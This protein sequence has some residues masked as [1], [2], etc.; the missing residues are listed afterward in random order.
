M[1]NNQRTIGSSFTLEGPTL[2]F[3]YRVR[4]EMLPA[5]CDHGIIA[6]VNDHQV[7]L[8]E[9]YIDYEQLQRRTVVKNKEYSINTIEHFLAALFGLGI[10]NLII[11]LCSPD[12]IPSHLW[13]FPL[14]DGCSREYSD[15]LLKAGIVEQD[16]GRCYYSYP[17]S[18]HY[19]ANSSDFAYIPWE[20]DGLVITTTIY[21]P[22]FL[23]DVQTLSLFITEENFYQELSSARTF[24]FLEDVEVLKKKGLIKGGTL[25]EALVLGKDSYLNPD[26]RFKDEPVRHKMLDFLGDLKL[27]GKP[28]RG[29]LLVVLGGHKSHCAFV[30]KLKNMEEGYV[31]KNSKESARL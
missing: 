20:I 18:V 5:P 10:D 24:C 9:E 21:H 11:R 3:G 1:A 22:H 15:A 28:L 27:L 31:A 19:S 14:L 23:I 6:Y 2:H 13:E 8:K 16:K 4:L 17:Y 12:K 26:L 29:H 7:P 30:N 25:K